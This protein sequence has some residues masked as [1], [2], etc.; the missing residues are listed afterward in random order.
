M[1]GEEM[2]YVRWKGEE[3]VVNTDLFRTSAANKHRACFL[4]NNLLLYLPAWEGAEAAETER[5]AE[6]GAHRRPLFC[7]KVLPSSSGLC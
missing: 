1:R 2:N 4:M 7:W 3:R 6:M 5:S